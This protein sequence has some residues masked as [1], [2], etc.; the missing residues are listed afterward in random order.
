[1][2]ETRECKHC[3]KKI[4][5]WFSCLDEHLWADHREL[6]MRFLEKHFKKAKEED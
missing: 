6:V 4:D 3:G 5:A 1:M 2:P